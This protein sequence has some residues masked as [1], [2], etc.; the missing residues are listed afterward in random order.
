[1]IALGPPE[2]SP[3]LNSS[4]LLPSEVPY[5]QVLGIRTWTCLGGHYSLL[6]QQ[7]WWTDG[8]KGTRKEDE[9]SFWP[10]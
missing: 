10:S 9:P 3:H 8:L 1:M 5:A 2:L 4:P 6:H 7:D